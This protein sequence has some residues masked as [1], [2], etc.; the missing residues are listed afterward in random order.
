MSVRS[1]RAPIESARRIF[2]SVFPRLFV[3]SLLFAVMSTPAF[4]AL[5]PGTNTGAIPNGS[6][7]TTCGAPRDVAFNVS[8]VAPPVNSVLVEITADHLYV[9]DLDVALIA[10]DATTFTL[11][12][13]PGRMSPTDRGFWTNLNGTYTFSDAGS[14]PFWAAAAASPGN[15]YEIP[16]GSYRAQAGGPFSS[17]NP[18]PPVTQ[19]NTAFAGVVNPNGN[20]TLRVLDCAGG[21]PQGDTGSVSSAN[22]T[23]GGLAPTAAGASVSGRVL[24]SNGRGISNVRVGITGGNLD[25]PLIA[26]TNPFGFYSFTNIPAGQTYIL[27]VGSKQYLFAD[28][29]RVLNLDDDLAGIDFT[30]EPQ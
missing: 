9:G 4:A 17:P 20:W 22:L 24:S 8:G 18:G 14:T 15:G 27:S 29:V 12:R 7:N 2:F 21:G 6:G 23:I 3:S 1:H 11:F 28:P 19:L 13:F 5:A 10:P 16:G 25:E 30:A 26:I